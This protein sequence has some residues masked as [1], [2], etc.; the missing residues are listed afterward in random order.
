M[1][2][3]WWTLTAVVVATFML[4]LDITVVNTALPKIES[5][6]KA[7]FTDLQWVIDAYALALATV[8]LTAGSLADRFGRKRAFMIGLGVFSV[9]S[10]ACALAP[11]AGALIAA[12][13]VQ[14]LG[15]AVMFAISLALVAQEF[16]GG[17]ERGMALGVYGATIGV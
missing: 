5:G 16:P 6:L 13:A 17:R 10:L 4:L 14:G 1:T 9:A 7:S 2:R 8:V 3:R 15:G 12:R 11:S